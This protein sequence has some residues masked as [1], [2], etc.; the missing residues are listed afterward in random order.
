MSYKHPWAKGWRIGVGVFAIYQ[1]GWRPRLEEQLGSEFWGGP[2]DP[3]P[4]PVA[5]L[6][7]L[8]LGHVL[9]MILWLLSHLRSVGIGA[10]RPTQGRVISGLCL[11]LVTPIAVFDWLPWI[12]I[13]VAPI[14][15]VSPDGFLLLGPIAFVVYTLA[16]MIQHQTYQR[17]LLRFGL[18]SLYF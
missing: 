17:K 9:A 15:L 11:L 3:A 4:L 2:G 13:G 16:A 6:A 14:A 1:I 10:F 5:I 12:V 8:T 18:F 7:A